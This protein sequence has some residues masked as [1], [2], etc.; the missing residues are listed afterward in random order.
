MLWF[1]L[2]NGISTTYGLYNAEI[3]FICKSLT[4]IT[5][6]ISRF[7]YIFKNLH[8]LVN[9]DFLYIVIISILV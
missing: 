8:L 4:V 3:W 6:I 7:Y 5:I 1:I 9:N 2:F